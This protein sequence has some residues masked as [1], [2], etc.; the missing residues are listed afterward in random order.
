[1]L[2]RQAGPEIE[3]QSSL[4]RHIKSLLSRAARALAWV[5]L[6]VYLIACPVLAQSL[7]VIDLRYRTAAEVI[8]VLQPLLEQGGA[9]TGQDYKLFVRASPANVRQIR[10]ALSQIDRKPNQLLV[11]VRRSAQQEVERESAQVAGTLSN[12]GSNV[13]VQATENDGRDRRD[14]V[15]SVQVLEGNSAFI[16][17]GSDV[18]IVTSFA[19]GG[20]RRPWAA[21]TTGYRNVS[22]GFVVTPRVNGQTVVLDIEQ[23]DERVVNG[24]VQTQH[25]TTQ[26]SGTLGQWI[27]LGGVRESA[28]SQQRGILSRQYATHSDERSIWIK[29]DS[30]PGEK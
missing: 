28:S 13:S 11:S 30:V 19:A 6:S 18:P 26:V 9:L 16:S 4:M 15:A 24:N 12:G 27:Q 25:L 1:M 5:M 7:E 14:G 17:S 3:A 20:G 29:V 10:A 22:S 21:A 23:Q 8:P 2:L